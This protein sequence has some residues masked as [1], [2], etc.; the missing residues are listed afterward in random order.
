[1]IEAVRPFTIYGLRLKGSKE[2]RY[3]GQTAKS[4]TVR[5]DQHI[6]GAGG[7]KRWNEPLSDWI[8]AHR[9]QL[10]IFKIGYADTRDDA[11]ALESAII[12]LCS[13]LEHRLFN[14]R[15]GDSRRQRKAAA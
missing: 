4:I 8:L 6:T 12:A 3:V 11:R 13:R 7:R 9:D 14:Q 5:L 10:E 15:W 2:V 1:M